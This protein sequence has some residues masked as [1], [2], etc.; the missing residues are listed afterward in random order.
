M[1]RLSNHL[2]A[3]NRILTFSVF[4]EIVSEEF[5]MSVYHQAN[6]ETRVKN[7]ETALIEYV[8]RFGMTTA[9][10]R[11]IFGEDDRRCATEKTATP[12]TLSNVIFLSQ[13]RASDTKA[14]RR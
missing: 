8:Q 14:D 9:A 10:R 4:A 12:D 6:A 7:L 11:A 5:V 3:I 2:Y 1:Q 13:V